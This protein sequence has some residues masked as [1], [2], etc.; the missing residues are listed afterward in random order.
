MENCTELLVDGVHGIHCVPSLA[1]RYPLFHEDGTPLTDQELG[2]LKGENWC[3]EIDYMGDIY[4]KCVEG[5]LWYVYQDGDIW[6]VH[7]DAEWS[8]SEEWFTMP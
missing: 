7:P 5:L 2:G 6:A 8:D 1:D 4:V 3:E